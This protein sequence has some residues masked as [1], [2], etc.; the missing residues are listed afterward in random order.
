MDIISRGGGL[1]A[2][3]SGPAGPGGSPL[4]GKGKA[5]SGRGL[6]ASA[7]WKLSRDGS[8]VPGRGSRE[9]RGPGG[10]RAREFR[11]AGRR[12]SCGSWRRVEVEPGW[13]RRRWAVGLGRDSGW[14][15]AGTGKFRWSRAAVALRGAGGRV[16]NE[17]GWFRWSWAAGLG[18]GTGRAGAGTNEFRCA[19][20]RVPFG[21][22][23]AGREPGRV[24]SGGAGWWF[25]CGGWRRV[26][27]EPGWFRWSRAVGLGRD[28]GRAGAGTGKFR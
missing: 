14:A 22:A 1:S 8:G 12:F 15:G 23:G 11:C 6:R 18:R 24:S 5:R 16:E 3:P 13:F 20:R 7:G 19:G 28:S 9:G 27:N 2:S 25:P 26:E 21:G 10:D 4:W 17:P